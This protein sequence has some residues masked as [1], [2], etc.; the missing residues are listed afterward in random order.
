VYDKNGKAMVCHPQTCTLQ[1]L[2]LI[3][4]QVDK[5][6]GV[7]MEDAAGFFANVFGGERFRDW[8]C[9]LPV[10][11]RIA[12]LMVRA[13]WRDLPHEGDDVRGKYND[14]GGRESRD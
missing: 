3:P 9:V 8:V 10:P 2:T 12:D 1:S 4:S 11:F 14:V 7:G 6:G 13:D 5:E